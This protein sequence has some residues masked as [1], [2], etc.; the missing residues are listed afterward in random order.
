MAAQSSSKRID[1]LPAQ[2]A[3]SPLI[4]KSFSFG[5]GGRSQTHSRSSSHQHRIPEAGRPEVE[6]TNRASPS[7]HKRYSS[8]DDTAK[9]SARLSRPAQNLLEISTK[10]SSGFT[11][12]QQG[13]EGNPK[14]SPYEFNPAESSSNNYGGGVHQPLKPVAADSEG[15]GASP[16][17]LMV[18]PQSNFQAFQEPI[19]PAVTELE[20]PLPP[21]H[22]L[23]LEARHEKQLTPK[24]AP[25]SPSLQPARD[26]PL[27]H[28][29]SQEPVSGSK[30]SFNKDDPVAITESSNS[31]RTSA[32][33]SPDIFAL[34]SHSSLT[35]ALF[36]APPQ[37]PA[38]P[39]TLRLVTSPDTVNPAARHV[40]QPSYSSTAAPSVLDSISNSKEESKLPSDLRLEPLAA[41]SAE[42]SHNV[43]ISCKTD[44]QEI[45]KSPLPQPSSSTAAP[46]RSTNTQY[47]T[48]ATHNAPFFLSPNSSSALLDFLATTPPTT[49]LETQ[50]KSQ[51]GK[52]DDLIVTSQA[53]DDSTRDVAVARMTAAAPPAL[54]VSDQTTRSKLPP[55]TREPAPAPAPPSAS[56][57]KKH[58][59][60]KIFGA[61][62]AAKQKSTK[63]EPAMMTVGKSEWYKIDRK[64]QKAQNPSS[65][66][67]GQGINGSAGPSSPKPNPNIG[68]GIMGS[69]KDAVWI[70]GK[71]FS[72]S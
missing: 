72:K 69:G 24:T 49:P 48:S 44:D 32:Q 45:S 34:L 67:S 59:W 25:S 5:E 19:S 29:Q 37:S 2:P 6:H 14:T 55:P 39:S 35:T 62:G 38:T 53:N 47:K 12:A 64:K 16:V 61:R 42:S 8:I 9:H 21:S 30:T 31:R 50:A 57:E 26:L 27:R 51:H 52:I 54:E 11:G 41:E 28:Y 33:V 23:L 1:F 20:A 68:R 60:K 17:S 40:N 3:I 71:N 18:S 66:A 13:T 7:S 22:P 4:E 43:N 63:A 10:A 56:V 70:S 46:D 15:A 65:K 58:K 36:P